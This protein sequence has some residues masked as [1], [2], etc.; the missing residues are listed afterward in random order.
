MTQMMLLQDKIEELPF[1][2]IRDYLIGKYCP[3]LIWMGDSWGDWSLAKIVHSILKSV[4]LY[5]RQPMPSLRS[6]GCVR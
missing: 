5:K 2:G 1:F 3:S 6:N 4:G